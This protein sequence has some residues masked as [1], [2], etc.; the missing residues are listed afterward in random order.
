MP[1][2]KFAEPFGA[3]FGRVLGVS[4]GGSSEAAADPAYIAKFAATNPAFWLRLNE[5]SGTVATDSGSALANGTYT[6]GFSL[7]QTGM[8]DG[9]KA[10]SFNGSTGR[11]ALD[12][13]TL[14]I[15]FDG[16][17]GTIFLWAKIPSAVWTNG[18]AGVFLELGSG[19]NNRI[20][21]IKD[22][23]S[24]QIIF[25]RRANSA[26]KQVVL[27]SYSPADWFSLALTWDRA[28][29]A[30]KAFKDG[31]QTGSTQTTLGIWS[32]AL[33]ASWSA[34]A[35]NDSTA[36]SGPL[37]GTLAHVALWPSV[38]APATIAS[39]AVP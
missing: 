4:G 21:I 26:T 30:L 34:I 17:V 22:T 8:G 19:V 20:Y 3:R 14:D 10:T 16:D 2:R 7:N 27:S 33:S 25:V 29:N 23:T 38:L 36:P 12:V 28:G 11:V 35:D 39:L 13:A 5:N 6:G 9:S 1:F 18:V 24:N 15:P 32:G 37:N 31:A